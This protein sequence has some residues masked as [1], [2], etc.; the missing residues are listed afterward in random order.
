MD[1]LI[2][3]FPSEGALP[4]LYR[5]YKGGDFFRIAIEEYVHNLTSFQLGLSSLFWDESDKKISAFS[6][7]E[8]ILRAAHILLISRMSNGDFPLILALNV[9]CD[10]PISFASLFWVYPADTIFALKRFLFTGILLS[11]HFWDN[12]TITPISCV[13]KHFWDDFQKFFDFLLR[14]WDEYDIFNFVGREEMIK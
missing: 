14:L 13:V 10:M 3:F 2:K 9:F 11:S 7:P 6:F 8:S 1:S 4:L 5:N 12:Y